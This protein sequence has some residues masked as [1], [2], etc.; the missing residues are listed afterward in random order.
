[1]KGPNVDLNKE[2]YY[3]YLDC[4]QMV[5]IPIYVIY[6]QCLNSV[7]SIDMFTLGNGNTMV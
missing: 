6:R 4:I 7:Y 2:Y 5:E 1:M 3:F